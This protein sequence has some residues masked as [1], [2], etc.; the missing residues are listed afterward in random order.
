MMH[1]LSSCADLDQFGPGNRHH[2]EPRVWSA[3]GGET[4]AQSRAMGLLAD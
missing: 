1:A 2:L 4:S 3:A